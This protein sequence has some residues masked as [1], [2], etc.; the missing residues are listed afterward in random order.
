MYRHLLIAPLLALLLIGCGDD[1]DATGPQNGDTATR[2]EVSGTL[3]PDP[4]S[5]SLDAAGGP[6]GVGL[7]WGLPGDVQLNV[8]DP[9]ALIFGNPEPLGSSP[10]DPT[11]CSP[12]THVCQFAVSDV[13]ISGVSVGLVAHVEDLRGSPQFVPTISTLFGTETLQALRESGADF[14]EGVALAVSVQS[15]STLAG[16]AAADLTGAL[17]NGVLYGFMLNGSQQPVEGV[18]VTPSDG[19]LIEVYYPNDDYSG[20]QSTTNA[21]GFYF[22]LAMNAESALV[23]WTATGGGETWPSIA[24][25]G[26]IP[27]FAL[28]FSWTAEG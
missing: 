23:G 14:T 12:S 9:I 28:V 24:L 19:N 5:L 18:T 21:D 6:K 7:S 27:G 10:L 4:V 11:F 25:A 26:T 22:A 16:L 8:V 17:G 20:L 1:D 13:D 15:L 3:M 2:I